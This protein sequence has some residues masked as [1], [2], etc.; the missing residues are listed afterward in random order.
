LKSLEINGIDIDEGNNVMIKI[1][2]ILGLVVGDNL[3]L[4]CFLNFSKS[5]S[6]NYF[7]RLCRA[8]KVNTQQLSHDIPEIMRTVENYQIDA[9]DPNSKGV[10]S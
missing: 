5:F 3:G 10:L 7:C 6:S 9:S 2:F 8:P 4:N 1:H